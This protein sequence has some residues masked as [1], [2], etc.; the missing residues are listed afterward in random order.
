MDFLLDTCGRRRCLL[1]IYLFVLEAAADCP[2]PEGGENIVLST[3][4]LLLNEFPEGTDV[5]LECANGYEKES[6]SVVTS[7]TNGKW[8]EPD[9]I[10]KKKDCGQPRP[11][12]N[13]S[14]NTS[15]GTL[16][17]AVIRVICDKGYQISGS[18]YRQCYS[19]GWSGRSKC[20]IITCEKP[21]KVVNGRSLWD[22]QDDPRYGEV[23]QFVCNEGYN[24]VGQ[25][26]IMCGETGEFNSQPPEC[27]GVATEDRMTT[28]IITPTP[29]PLT[30]ALSTA[31]FTTASSATATA[32]QDKTVTTVA[33]SAQGGRDFFTAEARATTASVTPTA[34]SFQEN[35][36][37]YLCGELTLNCQ[38]DKHDE[39]VNTNTNTGYTY[40]VVGVC[41]CFL[42]VV[43]T[44]A[45]FLCK[46][47]L[48]RKG[49]GTAPICQRASVTQEDVPANC[50][51]ASPN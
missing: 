25:D 38:T 23:I 36:H 35:G 1:F 27:E 42:L 18:S 10:C 8:T 43:C 2:K 9:L 15:A 29:A 48:R 4:A 13:M 45:V 31:V 34:S 22:S 37:Y 50:N 28:K 12:P 26:S 39:A 41:L 14:F 47:F 5:I 30:Q 24:L 44:V 6:G 19:T 46:I 20:K 51:T 3:A 33:P 40:A 7:C 21:A 32:H 11:Q 16:F 49:S 17:G